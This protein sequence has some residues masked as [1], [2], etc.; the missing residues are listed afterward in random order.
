LFSWLKA[1]LKSGSN[2]ILRFVKSDPGAA[3][4][5]IKV[6]FLVYNQ[7]FHKEKVNGLIKIKTKVINKI[8]KRPLRICIFES[9]FKKLSPIYIKGCIQII[10]F[11]GGL[12]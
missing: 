1:S 9:H 10:D 12:P 5:E 8:Y 2:I 3:L 4:A 11:W 7:V 6:Q